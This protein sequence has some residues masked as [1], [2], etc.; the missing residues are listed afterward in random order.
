MECFVQTE[1][2][3]TVEVKK[4]WISTQVVMRGADWVE[5]QNF[6]RPLILTLEVTGK[7]VIESKLLS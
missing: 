3:T 2:A 5:W 6:F 1:V 4:I 7:V